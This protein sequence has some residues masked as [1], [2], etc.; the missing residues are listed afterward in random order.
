M[1]AANA[2]KPPAGLQAAGRKLWRDITGAYDFAEAPE[3]LHILEA[4]CRA[5]D[6]AARAQAVL[7]ESESLRVR[8]SGGANHHVAAPEV[9]IA[10]HARAA[11]LAGIK[12]LEL[13]ADEE[14]GLGRKDGF[15]PMSRQASSKIANAARWHGRRAG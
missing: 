10:R 2:P 14:S 3:K 8:G 9:D 4:A 6:T 12:Q 15:A 5:A 11:M 13:P 7:D 1:T